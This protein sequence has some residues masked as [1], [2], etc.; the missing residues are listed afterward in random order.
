MLSKRKP[1]RWGAIPVALAV[2]AAVLVGAPSAGALTE[3]R[4]GVW[5][6]EAS[7]GAQALFESNYAVVSLRQNGSAF[8]LADAS[9]GTTLATFALSADGR[10]YVSDWASGLGNACSLFDAETGQ[11]DDFVYECRRAEAKMTLPRVVEKRMRG[12][13]EMRVDGASLGTAPVVLRFSE[14]GD[15]PPTA[16]RDVTAGTPVGKG[17]TFDV[18]V[19]WTVPASTGAAPVDYYTFQL[20]REGA[21]GAGAELSLD[22]RSEG[23]ALT[24]LRP[25]TTYIAKVQ[26][27]SDSGASPVATRTFRTPGQED[28]PWV[29]SLGD[30]FISGE[31]GRWA[32]NA[33]TDSHSKIDALGRS[34]YWD[35][36]DRETIPNCNRSK[37]AMIHI[38]V[39]NSINFACSGAVTFSQMMENSVSDDDW[40]PGIDFADFGGGRIGQAQLL[41]D[42]AQD[43]NVKMVALS[44]GGN[45]VGFGSIIAECLSAFILPTGPECKD[46]PAVNSRV[47]AEALATAQD[48]IMQAMLNIRTAMVNAGKTDREWV[49]VSTLYPQPMAAGS[50]MRY[51]ETEGATDLDRH[52]EGGCGFFNGDAS[53]ANLYVLRLINE[54]V[55]KAALA[56]RVLEPGF[57]IVH[58]DSSRAFDR[59]NLC[60]RDVQRVDDD[61]EY[62]VGGPASW[63][64][65][66]AVD[67]SEWVVEIE[68]SNASSTMQQESVHPNYWGQLALRNCLR[69]V[70]NDGQV[71]GGTCMRGSGLN[72]RGEPK[73]SLRR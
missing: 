28:L 39:A 18:P 61:D 25:S 51:P 2:A 38:Q 12:T 49:L 47:S 54:T 57:R 17:K 26:A 16:P 44:I 41:E 56:A 13:I 19:T 29:V 32:G 68:I 50:H 66:G 40:K 34:A 35:A 42:F 71:M 59:R 1:L 4:E 60:H 27:V 53:W 31:G 14:S 11:E 9:R 72:S 24:G 55:R 22:V 65:P 43:H 10:A 69:Q 33:D 45:N 62:D 52:Y 23:V 64:E 46:M 58:M 3:P 7:D 36:G 20:F 5:S 37:T 21:E 63:K 15:L 48:Q 70:W 73:M 8:D 30:S 67:R 6:L